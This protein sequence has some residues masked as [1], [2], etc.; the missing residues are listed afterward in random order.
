M[1]KMKRAVYA[2]AFLGLVLA[3]QGLA[4]GDTIGLV[5]AAEYPTL[6]EAV[7][8]NP[9]RRIYVPNG[10]YL[11]D[12]PLRIEADGTELVGPVSY[13]HLTLPTN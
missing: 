11:L 13:T 6:H 3:L 4:P 1:L 7:A 12:R 10:D 2:G 9:G 8:Q 5:S